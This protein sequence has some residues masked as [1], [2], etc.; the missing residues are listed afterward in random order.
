MN[1]S[2]YVSSTGDLVLDSNQVLTHSPVETGLGSWE[3]TD[4]CRYANQS[5]RGK[6]FGALKSCRRQ[7][8]RSQ[9]LC[10][11]HQKQLEQKAEWESQREEM[12]QALQTTV[13]ST[14]QKQQTANSAMKTG[15][16]IGGVTLA[17]AVL[18]LVLK[19]K[20]KSKP[21]K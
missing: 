14:A 9:A 11:G 3:D 13:T 5:C 15:L 21:S 1:R 4:P 19:S 20:R 17:G 6:L 8:E 2:S 12:M 10:Q 18:F 7:R 16:T